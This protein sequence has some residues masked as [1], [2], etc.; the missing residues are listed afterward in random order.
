MSETKV[1]A[2][3]GNQNAYVGSL[4]RGAVRRVLSENEAKGR[5]SLV[6]IAR[7]LVDMAEEG[8]VSAA[9]EIFERVDGKANQPLSGPDGGAI[10]LSLEVSFVEPG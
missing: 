7:K 10:P 9:R 1:G 5:E 8:N 3:A 4:V 2:P 6:N